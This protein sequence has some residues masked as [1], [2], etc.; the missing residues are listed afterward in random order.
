M[1]PNVLALLVAATCLTPSLVAAQP[2]SAATAH[3]SRWPAAHSPTAITDPGTERMIAKFIA[4]M[5]IEQKVRQ[6]I[7]ADI[8]TITPADLQAYP[9]GSIL[10]GGN[11]GP[12]GNE[13]ASAADWHRLVDEYRAPSRKAG[14]N[15]VAIPILFGVDAVHGHSNLPGATIFPHN[16]GLG[17]AHDAALIQRI[18]EATADEVSASGIEWTFAPTLAMPQDL[19]WGRSYEGY[20]SDPA[21]VASYARAMVI[22][23][24]GRLRSGVP[25]G[26]HHVAATA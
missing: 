16:V 22:G 2:T 24:Q 19:R 6:L 4:R 18:G 5:T 12:Y 21:L 25:V 9:L 10:A 3:P 23:L 11:S 14:P 26:R 1:K 8:S 13:R 15:G 7:Q 20:S 17:A